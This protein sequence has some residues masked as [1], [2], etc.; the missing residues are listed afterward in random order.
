M[1]FSDKAI[2]IRDED[3]LN[4]RNFA[5]LLG[6]TILNY[7]NEESL[8]VGLLGG[9]GYGKTSI[10]NMTIDYI[11]I[12]SGM[13]DQK[14]LIM[15]FNPWLFS[16]QNNI[17]KKF[18]DELTITLDDEKINGKIK[19]YM[20]KLIPPILSLSSLIDPNRVKSLIEIS[21]YFDDVSSE[22][23]SLNNIKNDLDELLCAKNKKIIVII[24]DID[25]LF[26]FEIRQ[27]FQLV[28]SV[29][30]FPNIIYLLS[31]DR[32]HVIRALKKFQDNS[33]AEYLEKIVQ[34]SFD[35]PKIDKSDL[36]RLFLV[37]LDEIIDKNDKRFNLR[38]FMNVFPSI[39]Y[40]FKNLRDVK[41]YINTLKFNL[42]AIKDEVNIADFLGITC[43]QVF[44]PE[45]YYEIRDN[46]NLFAGIFNFTVVRAT[47]NSEEEMEKEKCEKIFKK[48][49]TKKPILMNLIFQLFPK[50]SG[51]YHKTNYGSDW[52]SGW[53]KDLLICSPEHFNT[54]FR[55]SIPRNDI[56]LVELEY[57]LDLGHDK[58][59][60]KTILND[61]IKNKKITAFIRKFRDHTE[62]IPQKNVENVI[63]V[64]LN[65]G[66]DIPNDSSGFIGNVEMITK[67][68][69][70][71]LKQINGLERRFL[72]LKSPIHSFKSPINIL[73]L[74]YDLE[75][76]AKNYEDEDT[77]KVLLSENHLDELK[78]IVCK[79][80]ES[81]A[82]KE[83][84]LKNKHFSVFLAFWQ[85]FGE[86]ENVENYVENIILSD[87]GLISFI[88]SFSS[89]YT[90]KIHIDP[91]PRKHVRMNFELISKFINPENIKNR[92]KQI[93][94]SANFQDLSKEEQSAII[95][96]LGEKD[97][98][99]VN[100]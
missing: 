74:I 44:E 19:S 5:S 62:K 1:H 48:T 32:K 46:K 61:L 13:N 80:I 29:A 92:V 43:I 47:T 100:E 3:E 87:L 51:L 10:L 41:R 83:Q 31:F 39:K 94:T 96:F 7:E 20:Q 49:K 54:Y 90:S 72:I 71:L 17:I 65:I 42:A 81:L 14:C 58:Q 97:Q 78:D 89:I 77:E 24:D 70:L 85:K 34:V 86:K 38:Q 8:V 23:I 21:E 33:A 40:F 6:K 30:D 22:E 76:K 56:S 52:L 53:R 84:F 18:F 50:I 37:Y 79:K 35:V 75:Y 99:E 36:E 4:R 2:K 9:W 26:D 67:I 98:I 16:N 93:K 91:L 68:I 73:D 15:E 88:T 12:D 64:L 82:K 45:V 59:Q 95:L 28:K 11:N 60:F 55:F 66:K 27:I 25:R 57:I 63:S 69:S